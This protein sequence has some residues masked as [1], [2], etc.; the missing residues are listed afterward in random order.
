MVGFPQYR[1]TI[2]LDSTEK[3]IK[4][5]VEAAMFLSLAENIIRHEAPSFM[6]FD[7]FILIGARQTLYSKVQVGRNGELSALM[8]QAGQQDRRTRS[9][10]S[11][12]PPAG[13]SNR[14][15][16]RKSGSILGRL[17][18]PTFHN[19]QTPAVILSQVKHP[20]GGN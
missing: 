3:P 7:V 9:D 8:A 12:A 14:P 6:H 18:P 15:K 4:R 10:P 11:H 13:C 2:H 19:R 16:F 20:S 1:S 17:A 5:K